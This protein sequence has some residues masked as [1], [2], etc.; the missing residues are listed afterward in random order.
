[1]SEIKAEMM[2]TGSL[3]QILGCNIVVSNKVKSVE[4]K[5]N[6][7]LI[8]GQPLVI[9]VKRDIMPE[10]DRDIDKKITKMNADVHYGVYL[11]EDQNAV[12]IVSKDVDYVKPTPSEDNETEE[13]KTTPTV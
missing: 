8:K 5:Y 10:R 11:E 4:G 13:N 6:N 12:K 3:G 2:I 1:M 9:E 7:F